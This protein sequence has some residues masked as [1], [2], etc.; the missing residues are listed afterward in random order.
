MLSKIF[1]YWY[2]NKNNKII[3]KYTLIYGHSGGI[4]R[5]QIIFRAF[6]DNIYI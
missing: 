4:G 5:G 6:V 3:E 2:L 1:N